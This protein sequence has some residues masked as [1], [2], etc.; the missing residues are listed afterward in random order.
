[1]RY[2]INWLRELSETKKT[3]DEI[4]ES[5]TMK[6]FEVEKEDFDIDPGVIVGKILEIKKHP[7]AD[8]LQIAKVD[9]GK[10]SQEI[11]CGAKN[12]AVGQ[13]VPVATLG[14]ILPGGMEIK[15]AE[16]RGV[17]S[18]GMLCAMD[19][20]GI[21]RDHR[22][23][24]I[25]GKEAELGET[26]KS[27]LEKQERTLEIKVLPDRAHDA[28]SHV[29]MAKELAVLE[30]REIDY[31]FEGLKLPKEKSQELVVEVEDAKLC[32][33][34]IGIVWKGVE[35]KDS[36]DWIQQKLTDCGMR[37]IN[38]IVDA[39][40]LIMLEL[41]NPIHAFDLEKVKNGQNLKIRVRKAKNG[42]KIVLLD[43][44]EKELG[45]EDLLI[46]NSE[47][48]L[49][50]AG[51]KGGLNSGITSET[52]DLV[53]EVANFQASTIRKTRTK[54]GLATDA[55]LRYEKDIDPNLCEWAAVRV[56]DIIKNIAGGNL[57]GVV[58]SYP[59]KVSNWK[60]ALDLD[61]VD[62]LL[63]EKVE[64][65]QVEK[66]LKLLGVKTTKNV[67]SK[68][69]DCEI[70]TI[71]ID[72]RTQ[73]DLIEEIGRIV[74]YEKIEA[75]SIRAELR[76]SKLSPMNAL[77][78]EARRFL[79]SQGFSE[80]Y[81][82]S[83]YGEKEKDV[84]SLTGNPFEIENP[85]SPEEKYFRVILSSGLL[86]N[87]AL[88]L[89][90]FS[91]FS[92]F[93]IGKTYQEKGG[94]VFE[95]NMLGGILVREGKDN[96][97]EVFLEAKGLLEAWVA[98]FLNSREIDFKKDEIGVAVFAKGNQI[99]EIR[100]IEEDLKNSLGI[101]RF[102][103]SLLVF[104]IDLLAMLEIGKEEKVF[105]EISRFPRA[106]RDISFLAKKGTSKNFQE[107]VGIIK[108]NG[109]EFLEEV[110]IFDIFEK[111]EEI[112]YA[113]HL[114]FMA[115][116]RTLENEEVEKGLEKIIQGLEKNGFEIRK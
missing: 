8:K 112:S 18:S 68:K 79:V 64:E 111:N 12:I 19:E 74:G 91:D 55:S 103:G 98:K 104:E 2:S 101:K 60:V 109:G 78:R 27:Y 66:I 57:E 20:L 1:M 113:F 100:L 116:D 4:V 24:F 73:E 38:N 22:G 87:A 29:G 84:L 34:Y 83:F 93:E 31:D 25:L 71:R 35:V 82:Y 99:G 110:E 105:K 59:K 62:D 54:L 21:G 90:N 76:P 48:N 107:I 43:G 16:I 85:V 94:K 6:S 97:E 47:G 37:P 49:G 23:I 15:E 39:T 52:K 106:P 75:Q 17:K 51:I 44:E 69:M 61:Y 92:L 89:N 115:K 45:A 72:L 5:L 63:G 86:R 77:S 88:N 114:E 26:V 33:R 9:L 96:S 50:L 41:G 10:K 3:V 65:K 11:V 14:T 108:N 40:N 53:I 13:K 102:S 32:P 95:K 46:A 30:G 80:V 56:L 70:P 28:F 7:N 58:D 81:N 42:E 67:K 36:P